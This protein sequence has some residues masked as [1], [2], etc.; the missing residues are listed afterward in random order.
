MR[1]RRWHIVLAITIVGGLAAGEQLAAS[2]TKGASMTSPRRDLYERAMRLVREHGGVLEHGELYVSTPGQVPINS[3]AFRVFRRQPTPDDTIPGLI[4]EELKKLLP[5]ETIKL[6]ESRR[7]VALS[8]PNLSLYYTPTNQEGRLCYSLLESE[9]V[10]VGAGC[11]QRLHGSVTIHVAN[12]EADQLA[13]YG[14]AA[15]SAREVIVSDP[16]GDHVA[17]IGA[18]GFILVTNSGVLATPTTLNI[19]LSTGERDSIRL[20]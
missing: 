9:T 15:D 12:L 20:R 7:L 18:N 4:G 5:Q 2:G 13:V 1:G 10:I 8:Q 17:T 11:D 3:N 6:S 16:S 14:L 19:V